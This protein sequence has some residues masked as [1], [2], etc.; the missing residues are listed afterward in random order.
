[1]SLTAGVKKPLFADD[2]TMRKMSPCARVRR[3]IAGHTVMCE[4]PMKIR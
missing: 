1:M 4:M 3:P 2:C